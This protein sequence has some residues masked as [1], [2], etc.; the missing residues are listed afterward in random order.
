MNQLGFS[1]RLVRQFSSGLRPSLVGRDIIDLRT[2]H[3]NEL[4]FLIWTALDVKGRVKAQTGSNIL[5]RKQITLLMSAPEPFTQ[6]VAGQAAFSIGGGLSTIIDKSIENLDQRSIDDLGRALSA[7]SDVILVHSSN[8][9]FI[10]KL[11]DGATVPTVAWRS[12]KFAILQAL[13][14]TMTIQEHFNIL[15][16]LTLSWVGPPTALFNSYLHIMPK[17]K[18]NLRFCCNDPDSSCHTS[19]AMMEEGIKNAIK[20][21]TN[22]HECLNAAEAVYRTDVIVTTGHDIPSLSL[23]KKDV[24]EASL[25]YLLLHDLPRG[26]SEI[27]EELFRSKHSA[28]WKSRENV[29]CVAMAV[30]ITL[31]QDYNP[32]ISEPKWEIE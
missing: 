11:A 30:L 1:S 2:I 13:A 25:E 16:P 18:T 28:I 32:F 5:N 20:S 15:S 14:D 3:E 29:A 19:P 6:A 9:S 12:E 22:F 4:K 21:K 10:S 23:K 24:D 26:K 8:H 7:A 27:S 31:T 17:M